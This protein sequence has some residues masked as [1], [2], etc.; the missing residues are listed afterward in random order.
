MT[1]PDC[2]RVITIPQYNMT[3]WFNA[4]LMAVFFSQ[5]MRE[6]LRIKS[7]AWKKNKHFPKELYDI[8]MDLLMKRYRSVTQMK[9]YSYMYFQ[10]ITPDFILKK[11]F[12]YNSKRFAFDPD[13]YDGYLNFNYL[14]NLLSLLS[15]D[16]LLVLDA[17]DQNNQTN[18]YYSNIFHGNL[19]LSHDG[20]LVNIKYRPDA[21]VVPKE[22]E[23]DVVII[24]YHHTQKINKKPFMSDF[25]LQNTIMF[26]NVEYVCDSLLLTNYNIDTCRKGHDIAG[27]TCNDQKY[28][29]NGWIRTTRDTSMKESS[30]RSLPCEL[31]KYD[32]LDYTQSDFC[33]NANLCKLDAPKNIDKQFNLC[34]NVARA[35]RTLIFINKKY[36]NTSPSP[37]NPPTPEYLESDPVKPKVPSKPKV[38]ANP[39]SIPDTKAKPKKKPV[40]KAIKKETHPKVKQCPEGKILN[41]K[42]QRCVNIDGVIGKALV[43]NKK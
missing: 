8:A 38:K 29:Y 31:M 21:V 11:L 10:I 35:P 36:I 41:P 43:K 18:L 22:K 37:Y 25:K 15:V 6:L 2:S 40:K 42:T 9:E 12:E 16:K 24:Y 30:S 28:L 32:W 7:A 4:I 26:N 34:F 33:L 39:D 23:F 20:S 1:R 27:V 19:E 13:K 17:Y 5:Y 14:P 3:C